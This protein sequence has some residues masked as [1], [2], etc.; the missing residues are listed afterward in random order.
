M[1]S[2]R[3]KLLW[4][5]GMVTADRWTKLL[6]IDHV[7]DHAPQIYFGD[8]FRMEYAE[9]P[10]AF[11]S[12]GATLSADTRFWVF[13]VAVGL[14]LLG[15]S[16]ILFRENLYAMSVWATRGVPLDR[17]TS[18]SLAIILGGGVGNLIDRST[19]PNH[20]VV[21]F[22]NLG[23]GNFRTGIFNVAD[24]AIMLGVVLLAWQSFFGAAAKSS[25]K[26]VA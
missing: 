12:L 11:L 20:G 15:A 18:F 19:R 22:L 5:V 10:G 13:A 21:D 25:A 7:K 8:L 14:F 4:I 9:N 3:A 24:M 17:I 26:V 16:V 6:A 2:L 23:I 1:L